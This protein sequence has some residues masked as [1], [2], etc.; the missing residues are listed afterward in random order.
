[1]TTT[2]LVPKDISNKYEIHEWRNAT[3]VL[4][5]A[6]PREWQDIIEVLRKFKLLRS[7]ILTPGGRKSTVSDALDREFYSKGWKEK[8][9]DTQI[10]VDGKATDSP[11]HKVDCFKN[12]V[13][14]EVEWNNKDPFYDRDLNNFRLL[15]DLRV[16]DVGVIITRTDGLQK[17]FDDLGRGHSFGQSTTHMGRLVPRVEGGGGGG[18][19]ILVFGV[20]K[21]VYVEDAIPTNIP[22]KLPE[23]ADIEESHG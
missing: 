23:D 3:A 13:A 7:S 6:C 15:F 19:P 17:I 2:K 1:M 18:C 21:S 14:L 12:R 20:G 4:A 9:F 5:N 10:V 16:I 11:T 8:S 22:D